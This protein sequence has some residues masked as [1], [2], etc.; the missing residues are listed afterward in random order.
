MTANTCRS[1]EDTKHV[2]S[3][4][5]E[6]GLLNTL[7]IE[8]HDNVTNLQRA[9]QRTEAE[10]YQ[11][12]VY[13]GHIPLEPYPTPDLPAHHFHHSGNVPPPENGEPSVPPSTA[14]NLSE[15]AQVE[16]SSDEAR[17]KTPPGTP[18]QC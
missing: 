2:S 12:A 11:E 6:I 15:S 17:V 18:L 13:D 4:R 7:I 10:N 5:E 8:N 3:L 1:E 14:S 16:I 9:E